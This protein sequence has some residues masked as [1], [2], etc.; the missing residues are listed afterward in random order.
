MGQAFQMPSKKV[1]NPRLFRS[2]VIPHDLRIVHSSLKRCENSNY[3]KK[4]IGVPQPSFLLPLVSAQDLYQS[5][6]S[7]LM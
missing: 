4:L 3:L 2:R 6:E 7:K 1:A 5:Q